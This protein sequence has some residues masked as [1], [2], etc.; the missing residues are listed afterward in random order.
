[1]TAHAL[2]PATPADAAEVA[3]LHLTIWRETYG[4]L[5]PHE[6]LEALDLPM[7]LRQW[8]GLLT[9]TD[10]TGATLALDDAGLAGFVT[11][12]PAG[13]D[14]MGERGEVKHLYIAARARRSGL[15][16]RLLSHGIEQLRAGGYPG[17]ALVVVRQNAGARAFY[18]RMGGVET[19]RFSDP[20]PLWRS[21][22]VMM[23]WAF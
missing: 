13:Y 12:G 11:I 16:T 8:T 18:T 19:A 23:T 14:Q 6:A 2:R 9:R 4:E 17:A 7:R 1:M 21:E 22:N 5:A 20:G 3:A 15:G 10:G